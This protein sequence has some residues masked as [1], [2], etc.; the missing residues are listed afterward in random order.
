M[1]LV[2]ANPGDLDEAMKTI[3]PL[4]GD[5]DVNK[6]STPGV[7][8][9]AKE[10]FIVNG[11]DFR[12]FPISGFQ[13]YTA[14]DDHVIA[15][16]T[17]GRPLI[18]VSSHGKGRVVALGY[19][20]RMQY[21][22]RAHYGA[23]LT[24]QLAISDSV[25][26]R[27]QFQPERELRYHYWEYH[28]ALLSKCLVWAARKDNGFDL[29]SFTWSDNGKLELTVVNRGQSLPASC[30]FVFRNKYSDIIGRKTTDIQLA[31]GRT[32]LSVSADVEL[33]HGNNYCEL[34][35]ADKQGRSLTWGAAFSKHDRPK[36]IDRLELTRAAYAAGSPMIGQL[37]FN[38]PSTDERFDLT[39]E[40]HDLNG[41]LVDRL[42]VDH[43]YAFPGM[44]RQSVIL[45][46]RRC[47]DDG[48]VVTAK[49]AKDAV[50]WDV[51]RKRVVIF[52]PVDPDAF[53]LSGWVSRFGGY[54]L[55]ELRMKRLREVGFSLA[56]GTALESTYSIPESLAFWRKRG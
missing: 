6:D 42:A 37:Y 52:T 44:S 39:F 38:G 12:I 47:L 16:S 4:K 36:F 53:Y 15:G 22:S 56:N 40:F 50:T 46:T 8:A 41:R 1:G 51:I 49:I 29:P 33:M 11:F 19:D 23:G 2:Y 28:Y 18:T 35:V 21:P 30:S 7:W 54:Y 17:D 34:I 27:P 10:H 45:S 43:T 9:K 13:P 26:E 20:A 31:T 14:T 25:Y 3:L 32:P 48:G 55:K 5:V 24:P